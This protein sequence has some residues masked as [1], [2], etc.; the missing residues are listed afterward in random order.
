MFCSITDVHL[1]YNW[2][3]PN[4]PTQSLVNTILLHTTTISNGGMVSGPTLEFKC[5]AFQ[6]YFDGFFKTMENKRKVKL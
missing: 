3:G 4:L 6:S 2:K 1:Y 5:A